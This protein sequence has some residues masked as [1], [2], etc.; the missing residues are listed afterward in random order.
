MLTAAHLC[1]SR[2]C[3]SC[4]G[5]VR[6]PAFSQAYHHDCTRCSSCCRRS[7]CWML[8]VAHDR[9]DEPEAAHDGVSLARTNLLHLLPAWQYFGDINH[10]HPRP[11]PPTHTSAPTHP[12]TPTHLVHPSH[13]RQCYPTPSKLHLAPFNAK[14]SH[15]SGMT[16]TARAL[17]HPH[18]RYAVR[19]PLVVRA[20]ALNKEVSSAQF[21]VVEELV[22]ICP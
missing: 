18:R 22:T 12:P 13:T 5:L 15:A 14:S 11:R 7:A 19:G 10:T 1:H 3:R 16:L 6:Q 4:R 20:E 8:S 17:A 9:V 2:Y 21:R